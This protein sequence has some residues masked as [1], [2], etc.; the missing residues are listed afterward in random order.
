MAKETGGNTIVMEF[1]KVL[2][3]KNL[4]NVVKTFIGEY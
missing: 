3:G 2:N 4:D 1:F